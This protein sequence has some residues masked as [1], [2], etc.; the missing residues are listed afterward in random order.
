MSRASQHRILL[1]GDDRGQVRAAV[2]DA[3]QGA[4]V[5][6]ATNTF[7]GIAELVDERYS[8]VLAAAEPISRRPLAAVRALR[9]LVGSGKLIL[10]GD[11]GTEPLSRRMVQFGCDDYLVTPI[12]PSHIEQVILGSSGDGPIRLHA[13]DSRQAG[14]APKLPQVRPE[15]SVSEII[16]DAL[17]DHPGEAVEL[18][19]S[20]LNK[21]LTGIVRFSFVPATSPAPKAEGAGQDV[22]A[23]QGPSG[24]PAG[25]L[26]LN[27]PADHETA[28]KSLLAEVGPL[29]NKAIAIQNRHNRLGKL[30]FTDDLTGIF[31][32]RYFKHFLSRKLVEAR[33]NRFPVTLFLFDIDNFKSYN[34]RFGHGVG[35]EILKQASSL[36][37][38]CVRDHDLVAR[39]GGD[40]FAVVFWE[41][42]SPRQPRELGAGTPGRPPSEPEQILARFRRLLESTSY[43]KLGTSG[44]G[45]L[46]ISGGL[47]VFPYDAQD[48]DSLIKAADQALMFGAKRSGRNSIQLVSGENQSKTI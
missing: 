12:Q 32:C 23:F 8:A 43:S 16:I 47:A 17:H 46:T 44:Q 28:G 30:A 21:R 45:T 1:I 35:D 22:Y 20:Q 15:A 24:A 2:N 10:F 7:D 13:D 25:W 14:E 6:S 41:K 40:E 26:A 29:L 31:N 36:M 33:K 18:V 34:D 42:D 39:I 3:L 4:Y 48:V 5:R 38:R 11:T 27:A 9:E 37:R 19:I